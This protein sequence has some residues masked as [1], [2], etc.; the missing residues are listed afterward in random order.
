MMD[1]KGKDRAHWTR[2]AGDWIKWARTPGHDAFWAYRDQL[3]GFIGN[4]PGEALEVGCGEGRVSRLLTECGFRVTATDPVEAF[5]NAAKDA[6]SA[7]AYAVCGADTLPFPDDLFDQVTAYNVLMDVEDV[8]AT[9][10]E[11]GRVLKSDGALTISIVHPFADIGSFRG[12]GPNA[13]FVITEPYLERTHFE[14][15][16]VQD[17][18]EMSFFGW[19]Q[20]LQN[21]AAALEQAGFAITSIKEPVPD[22]KSTPERLKN[23]QRLPLFLWLKARPF[24]RK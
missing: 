21:Y 19:S 23:W 24:P 13:P 6:T 5:I 11:V 9:L 1:G 14:E 10:S 7:N 16:M 2:I 17:G 3:S 15:T 4:G 12:A 8:P 18:L 22:P 20:P